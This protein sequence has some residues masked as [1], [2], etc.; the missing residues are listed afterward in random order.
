MSKR[1]DTERKRRVA[2][3]KATADSA[4]T[5]GNLPYHIKEVNP[6]RVDD[7]KGVDWGYACRDRG[8]VEDSATRKAYPGI[9]LRSC[10]LSIV[11]EC[12]KLKP[13]DKIGAQSVVNRIDIA[14]EKGGWT[15]NENKRL[16]EQRRKWVERA[17]GRDHRFVVAGNVHGGGLTA[18]QRVR[19][20]MLKAF[21]GI[22]QICEDDKLSEGQR[23]IQYHEQVGQELDDEGE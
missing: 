22:R 16:H 1:E 7:G 14:L 20:S 23:L 6:H 2:K 12:P 18:E 15:K 21:Q 17:H 9:V 5:T 10:Y 11:G 3:K 4:Y 13:N 8:Q 19:S